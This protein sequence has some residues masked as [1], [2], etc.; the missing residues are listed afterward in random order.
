MIRAINFDTSGISSHR[1]TDTRTDHLAI[2]RYAINQTS[3]RIDV[4]ARQYKQAYELMAYSQK[5]LR[6][7][8][9]L[10]PNRP[11]YPM[12]KNKANIHEMISFP[13]ATPTVDSNGKMHDGILLHRRTCNKNLNGIGTDRFHKPL[14]PAKDDTCQTKHIEKDF[15]SILSSLDINKQ[16]A[17]GSAPIPPS[18]YE[19]T[20]QEDFE[21]SH[22]L[23]DGT[24]KQ[25]N[26]TSHAYCICKPTD[27]PRLTDNPRI[28][29][30]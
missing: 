9:D 1:N 19:P 14:F 30:I 24:D 8:A 13:F 17:R 4:D 12:S 29:R 25:A 28:L 20:T 27:S 11:S 3:P 16:D 23:Q 21:Y 2:S 22:P 5:T 26:S 15:I 7:F 18:L 6:V 10:L